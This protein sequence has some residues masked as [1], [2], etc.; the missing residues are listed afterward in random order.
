[1][2]TMYDLQQLLKRF[3]IFIYTGYRRSDLDLMET[4]IRELYTLGLLSVE[5]FHS[6]I[7][8]LRKERR[9]EQ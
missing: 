5:E 4:E 9:T 2:R 8:I 6:A 3:G 1:M 7:L